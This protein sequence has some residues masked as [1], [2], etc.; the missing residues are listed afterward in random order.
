MAY[1]KTSTNSNL[2]VKKY[3]AKDERKKK[4]RKKKKSKVKYVK[5]Y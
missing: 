2:T 3:Y 1:S 5:K 4:K